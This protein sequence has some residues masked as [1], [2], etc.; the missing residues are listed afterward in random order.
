MT[1]LIKLPKDASDMDFARV[2]LEHPF[3]YKVNKAT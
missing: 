1:F 2:V 3:K